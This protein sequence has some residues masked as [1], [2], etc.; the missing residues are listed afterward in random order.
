MK[1][2]WWM[3]VCL[4]TSLISADVMAWDKDYWGFSPYIGVDAQ[5]R[6][7]PFRK[8]Y[9]NKLFDRVFPEANIYIGARFNCYLGLEF[10]YESARSR[11]R[12]VTLYAGDMA[13]GSPIMDG[14]SP[15]TFKTKARLY[16]PHLDLVGYY[17]LSPYFDCDVELLGSFGLSA[18]RAKFDRTT[19]SI[20]NL[21][22]TTTTRNFISYKF[23][24]RVSTGLQYMFW[25]CVGIRAT[26]T[27]ENTSRTH[28]HA[29]N[30]P[31]Q[32]AN[33]TWLR[34]NDSLIGGLGILYKF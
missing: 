8:G 11:K 4:T 19:V 3:A 28:S 21:P 12:E 22:T 2:S 7:M 1:K 14:A 26:I 10:G 23:M 25:E 31:D 18:I 13:V 9:G 30:D 24:P 32:V 33:P 27:W 20:A 16:G 17:P 5:G 29:T 15:V 6:Y 34:A